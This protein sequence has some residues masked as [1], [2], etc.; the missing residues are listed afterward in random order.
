M[1]HTIMKKIN[2][3]MSPFSNFADLESYLDY[4]Y[5]D[6]PLLC[7]TPQKQREYSNSVF[8]AM[9]ES[10]I[11]QE[12]KYQFSYFLSN[13]YPYNLPDD[14]EHY[15]IFTEAPKVEAEIKRRLHHI[16]KSSNFIL[17]QN[18]SKNRS[19]SIPHWHIFIKKT[20]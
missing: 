10:E 7:R 9:F 18:P 17:F 16:L 13:Q 1:A 15:L 14:V 3:I 6:F 2:I 5:D 8:P 19:V 4:P 12:L 11:R 20:N